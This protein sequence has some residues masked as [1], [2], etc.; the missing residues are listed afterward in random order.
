M[1]DGANPHAFGERESFA[2]KSPLDEFTF[3]GFLASA[4]TSLGHI[5]IFF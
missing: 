4:A 3:S 1:A 5:H 2:R